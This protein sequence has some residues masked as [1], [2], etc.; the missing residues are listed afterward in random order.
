MNE[1]RSNI[2]PSRRRIDVGANFTRREERKWI[3]AA[4]SNWVPLKKS[5]Q[6]TET[7]NSRRLHVGRTKM[8]SDKHRGSSS[9]SIPYLKPFQP[10][11]S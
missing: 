9:E 5:R 8:D 7:R 1:I 2:E 10:F 6:K 3:K 11:Q 4:P